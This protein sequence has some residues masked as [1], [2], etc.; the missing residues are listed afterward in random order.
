[1]GKNNK[2]KRFREIASVLIKNGFKE[3]ST[4]PEKVKE[5]LEELGPT[6]VKIG[7]ILSTRPDIFPEDYICEL[8]KLQDEVKPESFETIQEIIESQLQAP[9]KTVFKSFWES[10]LASASMAQVHKAMLVSGEFVVVK[11]KRP[12][13]EETML[14]DLALL[15]NLS[16]VINFFPQGSVLN[17]Q[18]VVAELLSAV[19]EELDFYNEGENIKNFYSLNKD[20]KFLK[21]PK[22]Y[23][24]F[25]T[26]D[27]LVMD[28]IEGYKISD[29]FSLIQKGY[30]LRDLSTKL[31]NN[32]FKQV[33]EDGFF[34]GDPH[35]GNILISDSKIAYLDFGLMGKLSPQL[36]AKFNVLLSSIVIG[37]IETL[38]KVVLQIG[39]KRQR[40]D[41]KKLQSDID[42]VYNQ[43]VTASVEEL[44]IPEIV[45]QLFGIC[46][47]HKISIPR[48]ITLIAKSFLLMEANLA[49]ISPE[50]TVME[51][52]TP[53]V[54]NQMLKSKNLKDE[55]Y[56]LLENFYRATTS[57]IKIPEKLLSVLTKVTSGTAIVQM[58]HTNL[59]K[60]INKL[61]KAADRISFALIVSSI[62]VGSSFIITSE[63]GPKVYDI[64]IL[65][66]L[67]YVGAALIGIWLVIAILR[68]GKI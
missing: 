52:A 12:N 26:N 18:E 33:F 47:T 8:R 45:D 57:S 66:L 34:H 21:I 60:N 53:Y 54:R 17:P 65:G 38:T 30:N 29:K 22:V 35:P 56:K 46:R 1:M 43:F 28:Y 25:T 42:D 11:V 58:E 19:R 62:I 55:S 48:D 64:S 51:I 63:V 24:T 68:S 20:I 36:R 4:T 5:T 15:N 6:F 27:I 50:L 61:T 31:I 14:T 23:S 7:Q 16:R 49:L 39:I 44:D 41:R 10:P 2:R 67:G 59:D 40:V 13:I 32:F 3:D 37:D 9:L